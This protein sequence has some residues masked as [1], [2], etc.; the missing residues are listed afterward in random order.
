[1]LLIT[2]LLHTENDAL[3]LGRALET[4]YP[5]DDILIVDHD[6]RDS[7][8]QLAREYGARVVEA[9]A[10]ASPDHYFRHVGPGWILCL[11]PR[12]SL[13]ESLAASL[14][15]WK[16]TYAGGPRAA[17]FSVFLREETATGWVAIPKAETRLIPPEWSRWIG[18]LPIHESSAISLDGELL[19]FIFP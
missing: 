17:A 16:Y 2:A 12:E 19:R 11:D 15:E 14:Y 4:L 8:V 6:S 13:T 5:C 9:V 1:M 10:N 7:T 18:M 3:R